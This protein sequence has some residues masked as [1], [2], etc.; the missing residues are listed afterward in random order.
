MKNETID[1][2][3]LCREFM[4]LAQYKTMRAGLRGEESKYFADKFF[5]MAKR[6]NE[7]PITY[8][9][10]GKGD[11]AIAYLHYFGGAMDFYITEKDAGSEDEPGQHQ[12]FGLANHGHGAEL[13][14]I[15]IVELI[16]NGIELDLHFTPCKLAELDRKHA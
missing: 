2:V 8:E 4:P 12:A 5:E 16:A 7:M 11:Q 1:A 3:E 10:D 6:I 9:Q 15:S 13:G 14:Y